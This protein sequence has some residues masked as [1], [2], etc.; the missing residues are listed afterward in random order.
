[1]AITFP[2]NYLTK[3]MELEFVKDLVVQ[4]KKRGRPDGP[5]YRGYHNDGTTI[6]MP[7]RYGH[8]FT[9]K[10]NIPIN[11][12]EI[13]KETHYDY[14]GNLRD[15]QVAGLEIIQDHL[16]TYGTSTVSFHPGAGKTVIG[17]TVAYMNNVL[18]LVLVHRN[19]LIKQWVETFNN[20]VTAKYYIVG[21][22]KQ[23]YNIEEAEIIITMDG[24]LNHIPKEILNKVGTLL[25]DEAH[26]FCTEGRIQTLLKIK[27][28]YIVA[29][30][31][32]P[33][34]KDGCSSFL[35]NMV[36]SHRILRPFNKPFK[37]FCH[38]THIK[39]T[40]KNNNAGTLDWTSY[41]Q[42]LM[43]DKVRNHI[44]LQDVLNNPDRKIL[45]LTKEQLHV[46]VLA[47][48]I[49]PHRKVATMMGKKVTYE[50]SPVLIGTFSKI[51]TGFD[52]ATNAENYDGRPIDMVIMCV[53]FADENVICQSAGRGLRAQSPIFYYYLDT[54]KVAENHWKVFRAW[55]RRC[56]GKVE[57]DDISID[58][59]TEKISSGYYKL[60]KKEE[61]KED[62]S[63]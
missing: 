53:S 40:Q 11:P 4:P 59:I 23:K 44:I 22:A 5:S 62:T 8:L 16:K 14:I 35:V 19:P 20:F 15:Y 60:S 41:T 13:I 1:M 37:I 47:D 54:S 33:D 30:T 27:P 39:P 31:A 2:A 46:D 25:I 52:V 7:Y 26:C 29:L 36:G 24:Q 9:K 50:D 55:G 61:K 17:T 45:I 32:T 10:N 63:Q 42:S 12:C 18:T 3:D 57:Y 6:T 51:S 28:R 56:G 49:S 34:R 58:D 48:L 38:R 21:R 43:N